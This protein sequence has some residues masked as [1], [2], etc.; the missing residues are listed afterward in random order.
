MPC[1]M[2]D[3]IAR[4]ARVKE[5]RG[6]TGMTDQP[7]TQDILNALRSLDDKVE[8]VG[9]ELLTRMSSM[10][11]RIKTEIAG[12]YGIQQEQIL[13]LQKRVAQIE[14]KLRIAH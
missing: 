4:W 9:A 6:G 5:D 2:L 3:G 12:A 8:G 10:E 7:T 11:Q 14:D 13:D 1:Q